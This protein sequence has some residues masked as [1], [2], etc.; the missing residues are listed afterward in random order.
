[1]DK[2]KLCTQD[3]FVQQQLSILAHEAEV[4]HVQQIALA[5]SKAKSTRTC[6]MYQQVRAAQPI[7]VRSSIVQCAC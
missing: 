7:T 3:A 6:Q 5:A 2:S 1:M 4:C